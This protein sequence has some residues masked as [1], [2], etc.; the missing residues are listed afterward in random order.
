MPPRGKRI[1][2]AAIDENHIGDLLESLYP[3]FVFFYLGGSWKKHLQVMLQVLC[4]KTLP[5]LNCRG[6]TL[7]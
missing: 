4:P 1:V 6:F 5:S 2:L 7:Q 3:N